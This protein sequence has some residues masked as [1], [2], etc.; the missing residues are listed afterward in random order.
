[1]IEVGMGREQQKEQ[2][3]TVKVRVCKMSVEYN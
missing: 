1:M 2:A 3:H